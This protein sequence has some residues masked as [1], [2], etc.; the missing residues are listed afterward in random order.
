MS[1]KTLNKNLGKARSAKKD[2][3]YTQLPDI[4]NELKHYKKHLKGKVVL[5]NC[6]DPRISNFFHYFSYG[7]EKLKLK[8]L[9]TT[10]YKNQERDFFSQN[11]SE[12]AIYLEYEGDKNAN[13]VPDPE[14]IGIKQLKRDGDFRSEE[15]IELLKQA[16]IV[17]TN[18]PF[19]LF[20]EYVAQLIK[21][22]KKFVIIGSYNAITYKEIFKFIKED[23][24]WLGNGFN[25]GN[26][27]FQTAHPKEFAKGVYNEETGLVK[28]RNVTWYTNLDINKR[29][30]D[31]ILYEK[32]NP[33]KYPTYDNYDAINVNKTKEIPA[34]YDGVMGVPITFMDKYNPEQFEILGCNRGVDQDPNRVYGRGSF[35]NG[36][37]TFKRL[38]I[39]NKKLG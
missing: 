1:K 22:D 9:I 6:D 38:F 34:D 5:C 11:K 15:C 21:Y 27:Y 18:P 29:H 7:F 26:A 3:F 14:E 28:F 4:E 25:N 30:E 19:S 33:E 32:Y 12:K 17:V 37:E 20:R 31:I 16:D 39:R 35:L 10:C 36:K 13:K 24:L 2:E 8:K 23:K